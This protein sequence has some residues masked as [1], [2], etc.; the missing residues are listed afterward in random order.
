MPAVSRR[1]MVDDIQSPHGD[2]DT[3]IPFC[4]KPL[5]I[6]TM[7]GPTGGSDNVL[8]NL[9]SGGAGIVRKNDVTIPHPNPHYPPPPASPA[10]CEPHHPLLFTHSPNVYANNREV[11]RIGDYYTGD[12]SPDAH[13]LITGSPNVFANGS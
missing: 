7:T 6:Q 4:L 1:D 5:V 2:G 8:V 9:G 12:V 13:P 11:G 3:Q 10:T